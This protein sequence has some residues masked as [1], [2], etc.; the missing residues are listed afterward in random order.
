MGLR[1]ADSII[2]VSKTLKEHIESVCQ[3]TDVKYVPN[4]IT[5]PEYVAA[6]DTLERYGLE[7]KKYIYSVGRYV[8][9]KGLD[10]LINAYPKTG[11]HGYKLV[12]SGG[13]DHKTNY[14][15]LIK[16]LSGKTDGVVLTGYVSG[17]P[18]RELYSNA[19]LFVLPSYYEGMPIAL[20]E[21]MS[22]DLDVVVS[23][24]PANKELDLPEECYFKTGDV[25]D[26]AEKLRMRLADKQ[27]RD[28]KKI[29]V[30]KYDWGKIAEQTKGIYRKL[31]PF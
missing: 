21:A 24:I 2:T 4:G 16:K 11:N 12:V 8:P 9:E 31:M 6:G 26:L 13:A 23:D 30:E 22:Y 18:M 5:L 7:P 3:R 1:Y 28:F 15:R 29:L 10:D 25:D 19:A 27:K 14:S 20:L 17:K